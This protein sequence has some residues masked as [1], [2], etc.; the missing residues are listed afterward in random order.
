MSELI[1]YVYDVKKKDWSIPEVLM[2][3]VFI[4]MQEHRLDRAVFANGTVKNHL[5]W[6]AFCQAKSNVVHLI[7]NEKQIEMVAWLNSFGNNYA[8]AHFCC[9]PQT[10]GGNSLELGW[11]CLDYWF[12]QMR[13]AA[14]GWGLDV[15][16]GQ[17]PAANR[18]AIAYTKKIGMH[19]L[20][21][22]PHIKY[23]TVNGRRAGA[24]FCY[25]TREEFN[26]GRQRRE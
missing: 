2:A 8:F 15:I 7:G 12:N 19:A 3:A 22:V 6:L 5:Q 24:Y 13:D 18:L 23:E 9:F 21:T 16:L 11:Q 1:P 26:N 10:W 20:G 4:T 25:I 17:I 14:S